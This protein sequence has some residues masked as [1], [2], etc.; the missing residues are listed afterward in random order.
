MI[1]AGT[2][3]ILS[4]LFLCCY[5]IAES[6]RAY[7]DSQEVLTELKK[8]IPEPV[9]EE[10]YQMM[11]DPENIPP[12]PADDLFAPYEEHEEETAV[13]EPVEIN[14]SYYCGF[15]T[16]P[17]LGLELPVVD[18]WSYAALRNSPCRYSGSAAENDLIIAAHNYNDHFGRIADLNTGDE[19]MFTDTSGVCTK[20]TVDNSLYFD[21]YDIDGMY[22][23]EKEEWDITLFT[24]TLSGQK[25]VT[26][27]GVRM[28]ERE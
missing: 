4:A 7:N 14:G 19:I 20:Y 15:I 16:L 5:N 25:R 13:P 8:V 10:E 22:S 21:G 27:R 28:E 26:I 9:V 23:G 3:L 17:S 24:C 2:M 6:R 12:N 18:G 11:Y 1:F